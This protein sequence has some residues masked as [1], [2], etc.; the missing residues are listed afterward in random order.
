MVGNMKQLMKNIMLLIV[1]SNISFALDYQKFTVPSV[2]LPEGQVTV[3]TAWGDFDLDGDLD[4]YIVNDG[5]PNELFMNNYCGHFAP[6]TVCK[7]FGE[8]ERTK[9]TIDVSDDRTLSFTKLTHTS[10]PKLTRLKDG[11]GSSKYAEWF[12]YDEDGDL[13][14]Y[15]VND[16]LNRLF[17]NNLFS[18]TRK[19]DPFSEKSV[20]QQANLVNEQ[21][22]LFHT[23]EVTG[24]PVT[25]YKA[26]LA[27][28][29]V[30]VNTPFDA[31]GVFT[32]ASQKF[33]SSSPSITPGMY[34]ELNQS[35]NQRLVILEVLS[36]TTLRLSIADEA[37][38][39][40]S[41]VNRYS[42]VEDSFSTLEDL[43]ILENVLVRVP[44]PVTDPLLYQTAVT[45]TDSLTSSQIASGDQLIM[46]RSTGA[47]VKETLVSIDGKVTKKNLNVTPIPKL[48][49]EGGALQLLEADFNTR[50]RRKN[51]E[52]V[53]QK[54]LRDFSIDFNSESLRPGDQI[55]ILDKK[56]A[57]PKEVGKS[58]GEDACNVYAIEA[59]SQEGII[60]LSGTDLV[61]N[62]GTDVPYEI[63]RR[64]VSARTQRYFEDKSANFGVP[65][66]EF[67]NLAFAATAQYKKGDQIILDPLLDGFGTNSFNSKQIVVVDPSRSQ[68][69][70]GIFGVTPSIVRPSGRLQVLDIVSP[71]RLLVD[72]FPEEVSNLKNKEFP[73]QIRS[74]FGKISD[75]TTIDGS[76]QL[77][78]ELALESPQVR[79]F[80]TTLGFMITQQDKAPVPPQI[81]AFLATESQTLNL[82]LNGFQTGADG[83]TGVT[84][85]R[86]EIADPGIPLLQ[87]IQN[88]EYRPLYYG[89]SANPY[90]PL[91]EVRK[92]VRVF[93]RL[94]KGV[95]VGHHLVFT[96][97]YKTT[98]Q[99][100]KIETIPSG[101]ITDLTLAS[102]PLPGFFAEL[103][104]ACN[105]VGTLACIAGD[106]DTQAFFDSE[107]RV[108]S[109]AYEFMSTSTFDTNGD[110]TVPEV[111][112]ET[113][114]LTNSIQFS[115]INVATGDLLEFFETSVSRLATATG[116]LYTAEV[117][118]I[119]S[120]GSVENI[121]VLSSINGAVAPF[122]NDYDFAKL[123][124]KPIYKGKLL[125]DQEVE[126]QKDTFDFTTK[127]NSA[128]GDLLSVFYPTPEGYRLATR[129][130]ID[131]V[132]S[133]RMTLS[134]T[135]KSHF[136]R[137]PE[138]TDA[139]YNSIDPNSFYFRITPVSGKLQSSPT[140]IDRRAD[141]DFSK[142][143]PLNS[144]DGTV[145]GAVLLDV[146]T[147]SISLTNQ[148]FFKRFRL[149]SLISKNVIELTSMKRGE[150]E[151]TAYFYELKKLKKEAGKSVTT[152][153]DYLENDTGNGVNITTGDFNSDGRRDLYVLNRFNDNKS[154]NNESSFMLG[155]KTLESNLRPKDGY[156]FKKPSSSF[157][158]SSREISN[159]SAIAN[160]SDYFLGMKAKAV[161]LGEDRKSDLFILNTNGPERLFVTKQLA[162]GA[163]NNIA[164]LFHI[165]GTES[166]GNL[167]G[168]DPANNIDSTENRD[169]LVGDLNNDNYDDFYYVNTSL[170][171]GGSIT[172]PTN[173]V[174]QVN[175]LYTFSGTAFTEVKQADLPPDIEM[176]KGDGISGQIVDFNNDSYNDIAVLNTDKA[177]FYDIQL[178][179]GKSTGG[180]LTA[181]T[182]GTSADS[183]N[184]HI[185]FVDV[186]MDG[187]LDYYVSRGGSKAASNE[188]CLAKAPINDNNN[189]FL[190][191]LVPR[192]FSADTPSSLLEGVLTIEGKFENPDKAGSFIDRS[193]SRRFKYQYPQVQRIKIGT[194]II[195]DVKVTVNWSNKAIYTYFEGKFVQSSN[196]T[197]SPVYRLEQ[198]DILTILETRK[199]FAGSTSPLAKTTQ[200]VGIQTTNIEGMGISIVGGYREDVALESMRVF[201]TGA[202]QKMLLSGETVGEIPLIQP[203]ALNSVKLYLDQSSLDVLPNSPQWTPGE[204]DGRFDASTDVLLAT[205]SISRLLN[206]G[207]YIG[208]SAATV[209]EEASAI[210][211]GLFSDISY[212]SIDA[213]G[214]ET[215]EKLIV[216]RH[217]LRDQKTLLQEARNRLGL[218]VV[219][220]IDIPAPAKSSYDKIAQIKLVLPL[221][222]GD[223]KITEAG[224]FETPS[225]R[226]AFIQESDN[227]QI[228]INL[229]GVN[230]KLVHKVRY[231][232]DDSF[233]F[234]ALSE[235]ASEVASQEL[236]IEKITFQE[237][238]LEDII[239]NNV[240]VD[241]LP[242][243]TPVL[244]ANIAGFSFPTR[245]VVL[246]GNKESPSRLLIQNLDNQSSEQSTDAT[247]N[248]LETW[249][250]VATN[251]VEGE[252]RFVI[253]AVDQYGNKTLDA[254][255]LRFSVFVDTTAPIASKMLVTNIG[256]NQAKFSFETNENAT[257]YVAVTAQAGGNYIGT[258]QEQKKFTLGG[259]QTSHVVEFGIEN[260][261]FCGVLQQGQNAPPFAYQVT[262]LCGGTEY[263]VAV[264]V[265]D[266][267]GHGTDPIVQIPSLRFK[268]P[269]KN[270]LLQD[271]DGEGDLD[272]DSDSD[273]LPDY[274]EEAPNYPDLDKYNPNDALLDFDDDGVNNVEEYRLC[275]LNRD[276][277]DATP[278]A[279]D[280]YNSFDQLPI[281][282]AGDDLLNANPGVLILDASKTVKNGFEVKDLTYI[283]EIQSSPT[284]T[285]LTIIPPTV[286]EPNKEKTFFNAKRSGDYIISL[287]IFTNRGVV[288]QKDTVLYRVKNLPPE[289]N[290]GVSKT[291]TVNRNIPLDGRGTYDANE[292][293]V[294]Y[295]WI[296][297]SGPS[298]EE[299]KLVSSDLGIRTV[300]SPATFFVT[301]S[302]GKYV[303]EL[304]AT[305]DIGAVGR[306]QVTIYVNSENDRFP[307]ANAGF[308][309][310]VTVDSE[311]QLSGDLSSA[312]NASNGIN[313]YWSPVNANSL[314][315][316]ERCRVECPISDVKCKPNVF[317][318][319]TASP[320]VTVGESIL[321]RVNPKVK[322][323]EP[324]LY[325]MNLVIEAAGKGLRSEPSC[326]KILVRKSNQKITQALPSIE[327]TPS[328]VTTT[329]SRSISRVSVSK[330]SRSISKSIQTIDNLSQN[331]IYKAPINRK[332]RISGL[333]SSTDNTLS[334]LADT[335]LQT[336][337]DCLVTSQNLSYR[338]R[339]IEGL[340]GSLKPLTRNCS[341][342]EFTPNEIGIYSF[343]MVY[344]VRE[345]SG[346]IIDSL[347]TVL[348][349]IANDFSKIGSKNGFIPLVDVGD[350]IVTKTVTSGGKKGLVLPEPQCYDDDKDTS[351]NNSSVTTFGLL[352]K[353]PSLFK[354]CSTI[355]MTCEFVQVSGPAA[356]ILTSGISGCQPGGYFESGYY[357]YDVRSFDGEYFSLT[358][359]FTVVISTE[360][361]APPQASAGF[362]ASVL[363]ND[364]V[365]LN[366]ASSFA[367]NGNFQYI[368]NQE[369]GPIVELYDSRTKSPFFFPDQEGN[370][371]FQLK[372]KD[373]FNQQSLPDDVEVF[374][375]RSTSSTQSPA[376]V[377]NATAT[378]NVVFE[379]TGGGGG[380]GCFVVT[381]TSGSKDSWLV[382]VFTGFRDSYL[383]KSSIGKWFMSIYYSYSPPFAGLIRESSVLRAVSVGVLYP[384]A[385]L[386]SYGYFGF[387]IFLIL[388]GMAFFI[389]NSLVSKFQKK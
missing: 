266:R 379:D 236:N 126:Y 353:N 334:V 75:K 237:G 364:R 260:Q 281:P 338:W 258:P 221:K 37:F 13:D 274:L 314:T 180:S 86:I 3:Y 249:Q 48:A 282:N 383:I 284:S 100:T 36:E 155:S 42:I 382:G 184:R 40:S 388:F 232:D 309:R 115:D 218:L 55:Q 181:L 206:D 315:V 98:R 174:D 144:E 238:L 91:G 197:G 169:I 318:T 43:G 118:R 199:L 141:M 292:D 251:L 129:I 73:Y 275:V 6:N 326:V 33:I 308:D 68:F 35:E 18:P 278:C 41:V 378:Q 362:D 358:D 124:I 294:T 59:V 220:T 111:F 328:S 322:Y 79:Q 277:N 224:S 192:N 263:K 49:D 27:V 200:V 244:N 133:T 389:M 230:S 235:T 135:L 329:S 85:Y 145:R 363:L 14:L 381:A 387:L 365:T 305:D 142:L 336:E 104:T 61:K 254:N 268:T 69:G 350:N 185:Q 306:D 178:E 193:F 112:S 76:I 16:G 241:V 301:R 77:F 250:F 89:I 113:Q 194:G 203:V 81:L 125:E 225:E 32:D 116:N 108:I 242:P 285:V 92:K 131:N 346:R 166:E 90:A 94:P 287:R 20:V 137:D 46:Y 280:M 114:M 348:T 117:L 154:T 369:S 63:I 272:L 293:K 5:A 97:N 276:P 74:M 162:E 152:G 87:D 196:T 17:I 168:L 231:Y 58:Y 70:K 255:A 106:V 105:N 189:Y 177:Y 45:Y 385:F 253:H 205:T 343:E 60:F 88:V 360:N 213:Q 302:T 367:Q 50:I 22:Y 313:Y 357:E 310:V 39:S 34:I 119:E 216:K 354:P 101:A 23:K 269:S 270:P 256:I 370:Y 164:T 223:E 215:R 28:P 347:P 110:K 210:N 222:V 211:Q 146:F 307:I 153:Q 186:N 65:S 214:A 21:D 158:T 324:G 373:S 340:T 290:A 245:T 31:T 261:E 299:Q 283:W 120:T 344:R 202:I 12:D 198:P 47:T 247:S 312:M 386:V 143:L 335:L 384:I 9:N 377:N 331:S 8:A 311:F 246:S 187:Y 64:G 366:G 204:P 233:L 4:A 170:P 72:A 132:T 165:A 327:G 207:R 349:I 66:A 319:Q 333:N 67:D 296:Q 300:T 243:I 239:G 208:D 330:A 173:Q 156:S 355:N 298:L 15:V 160:S 2:L 304:I 342:V 167:A 361:Q 93:N 159:R 62:L 99:I 30:N 380:G 179:K 332:L 240:E 147:Q 122:N 325:A 148:S 226:L 217:D 128:K 151:G 51:G 29:T 150:D 134:F 259:A 371:K 11:V 375:R 140:F 227:V 368:W 188:L 95:G 248:I 136:N 54:F 291:G 356:L 345:A 139:I 337:D 1:L 163:P 321:N 52:I 323:T 279:F 351:V 84:N 264:Y 191:D 121:A 161:S 341:L 171:Q 316:A 10:F 19:H 7:S 289:S 157:T 376:Q 228:D 339:Q 219:Y 80:D 303:F 96:N 257:G 53:F 273:G 320:F 374:V 317:A 83:F 297:V 24:L 78:E 130:P 183:L 82:A 262:T 109:T 352:T 56:Y 103:E 234:K 288:T 295:Q 267:L 176:S 265:E 25:G 102:E 212:L 123:G 201:F 175:E 38:D 107:P 271:L 149:K 195:R 190:F 229:V 372:I 209:G 71:T 359:K 286:D 127:T 44:G 252:N 182:C 57:C 138:L 172:A 26:V